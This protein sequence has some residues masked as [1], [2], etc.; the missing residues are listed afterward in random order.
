MGTVL[1]GGIDRATGYEPPKRMI[2]L[3]AMNARF[4]VQF[5]G[6]D[7]MMHPDRRKEEIFAHDRFLKR[8][9]CVNH[10]FERGG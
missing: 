8:R 4:H 5:G 7:R 6:R 9:A 10:A 3:A 2:E 1:E